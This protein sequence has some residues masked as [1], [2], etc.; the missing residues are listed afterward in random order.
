MQRNKA[1]S[2][3]M[4]EFLGYLA[5]KKRS[6]CEQLPSLSEIS[7]ELG[8]SIASVREQ[9]EVARSMSFVEVKPRTGIKTLPYDFSK[10]INSSLCYAVDINPDYFMEYSDLRQHLEA[11]YWYEA[12]ALLTKQDIERLVELVENAKARLNTTPIQTPYYE[13]REFHLTIYSRLNNAFVKGLM[14]TYW[15]LYKSFGLDV[16]ADLNYLQQVWNYHQKMVDAIASGDFLSGYNALMEHMDLIYK[17]P[18]TFS[19]QLFE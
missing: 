16:H 13:H 6:G 4:S 1:N 11:A 5:E 17:R 8:V 9:L 15:D 7:Q 19:K 3:T 18:R 12:V 10:S 14:Q 2:D